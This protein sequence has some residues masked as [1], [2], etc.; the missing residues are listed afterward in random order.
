MNKKL[1]C[2][3]IIG[4]SAASGKFFTFT[5]CSFDKLVFIIPFKQCLLLQGKFQAGEDLSFYISARF[6]FGILQVE[7]FFPNSF[8]L[9][10]LM[11]MSFVDNGCI[12]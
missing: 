10:F 4:E 9:P 1:S 5:S 8:P 3:Q 12:V 11:A 2:I 6:S 7:L